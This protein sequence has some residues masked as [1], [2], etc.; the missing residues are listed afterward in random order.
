MLGQPRWARRVALAAVGA[1]LV[2]AAA[3]AGATLLRAAP[4]PERIVL[5]VIDTLRR[6]RV[7]AYGAS[8][9]TPHLDA[10]AAEGAVFRRAT[11]A[12]NLTTLSMA[13]LFT[14][15]T[16]SVESQ[17]PGQPLPWTGHTWC[18]LSRLAASRAEPCVPSGVPTLA[19]E[20]RRAS[21]PGVGVVSNLLLFRPAGFD[22]GFDEWIEIG[23][24][25]AQT[26]SAQAGEPIAYDPAHQA[27]DVVNRAVRDWLARRPGDRFFLYVHYMDVHDWFMTKTPYDE[28][29]R[30]VDRHVGELRALLDEAGLLEGSVVVITSDHGEGLREQHALSALPTHMGNP[31]FRPVLAVPLIVWPRIDADPD[32]LVRSDDTFRLIRTLARVDGEAAEKDLAQGKLFLTERLFRTYRQGRWKSVW[33]RGQEDPVLLDLEQDPGEL[34]NVAAEHPE[35]LVAHRERVEALSRKLGAETRAAAPT[36]ENLERL[37]ALGYVE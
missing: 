16:P 12:F 13:A 10:F 35:R 15:R 8:V 34:R 21:Y 9:P 5:V 17:V 18:G 27:G 31:S 20:L 25:A 19:E 30:R 26:R 3:L 6:D 37:R 4:A 29:V 2:A 32:A 28:A 22:R 36:A 24:N 7:G 23:P 33:P 14:G 1:A 11:S